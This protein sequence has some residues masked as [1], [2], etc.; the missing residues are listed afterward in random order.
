MVC[1]P[2]ETFDDLA[3]RFKEGAPAAPAVPKLLSCAACLDLHKQEL[4]ALQEERDEISSL[5]S[6]E[7]QPGACANRA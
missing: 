3:A 7:I 6:T 5:D 2:R 4:A 1:V